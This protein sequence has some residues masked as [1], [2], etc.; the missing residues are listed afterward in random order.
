MLPLPL[1]LEPREP[2]EVCFIELPIEFRLCS[3]TGGC[4]GAVADLA[5]RPLVG[6]MAASAHELARTRWGADPRLARTQMDARACRWCRGTLGAGDLLGRQRSRLA[7]VRADV[8]TGL[9][10]PTRRLPCPRGLSAGKWRRPPAVGLGGCPARAASRRG[11]GGFLPRSASS[12]LSLSADQMPWQSPL[13]LLGRLRDR[14]EWK[15]KD[16]GGAKREGKFAMV[17][18]VNLATNPTYDIFTCVYRL[19]IANGWILFAG[20]Q[21]CKG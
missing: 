12:S 9:D 17:K 6:E 4:V 21:N 14:E 2:A 19:R 1:A 15:G 18:K 5:A 13:S 20:W 3:D 7:L 11:T 16:Q 8:A 10:A